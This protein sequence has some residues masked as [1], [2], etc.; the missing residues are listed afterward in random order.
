MG[1]RRLA[2]AARVDGF[3]VPADKRAQVEHGALVGDLAVVLLVASVT[4]VVMRWIHLPAVLGYLVAGLL[5]GP[6]IP[7]PV[8]ADPERIAALSEFGVVF[9]MFAVGLEF[10]IRRLIS[11]LPV[12]GFTAA[13]QIGV[14][15]ACGM[16]LGRAV[17]M[18]GTE[19]LFLGSAIAI[20]STMLVAKVFD[21]QPP[22]ERVRELVFGVLVVQDL[23]AVVLIAILTAM[24]TGFGLSADMLTSTV[25]KLIGLLVALLVVGL[26]AVPRIVRRVAGSGSRETL[27][28][29]S[30]AIC[31]GLATLADHLGYSVA[32]GAFLAG[33]LV[34]ESGRR[35]LIEPQ[36][37]PIRDL[38]AAVFFVSVGMSV[39]PSLAWDHIGLALAVSA[40]VI[41]GQFISV[42]VGGALSGN[43]IRRSVQGG[44]ALGQIGEFAFIIAGIGVAADVIDPFV[45]PVIVTVAV[46]TALTT[47]VLTRFSGQLAARVDRMLPQPV[48]TFVSLCES[49]FE[50]LRETPS[51]RA[52]RSH[53]RRVGL[54][55]VLDGAVLCG[56][57]VSA[58]LFRAEITAWLV[59]MLGLEAKTAAVGLV[60]VAGLL[61]APFVLSL[62]R[63]A[64]KTGEILAERVVPPARA[65]TPDL[66]RATRRSLVVA[67]QVV[68]V[69]AV[70]TPVVVL[71]AP[72]LGPWGAVALAVVTL[73]LG[74]FFWRT[75]VDL[76]GHVRASAQAIVALLREQ[77]ADDSLPHGPL[78]VSQLLPGL[79]ATE[80]VTL[81]AHGPAVGKT[82]AELDLRVVTGATVVAVQRGEAIQSMPSGSEKLQV[83]DSVILA[84]TEKAVTEARALLQPSARKSSDQETSPPASDTNA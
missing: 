5:C 76:H 59:E 84:G 45:Y 51:T 37:A 82:L 44:V 61:S 2:L 28:V 64:R 31:F 77:M 46:I 29:V 21:E 58:S 62:L 71:T 16:G 33:A 57:W 14:L 13:V 66:A 70:G 35:S 1:S 6:Y 9:V 34:A 30:L 40:I 55:L 17:G 72:V 65:G 78:G 74:F 53:V 43:G 52:R 23:V 3:G 10:S 56:L 18:S 54:V 25:G 49:W 7:I 39:D 83:G 38:F 41:V 19:A 11:V 22:D 50:T 48:Q 80:A 67:L 20:S 63:A 24:A 36:V 4:S 69:V 27:L 32:L 81:E 79:G 47:P 73:S 8:F 12:S 42:S 15:M 26:L 68:F 75:T 60:V